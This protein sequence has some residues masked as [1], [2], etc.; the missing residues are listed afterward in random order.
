MGHRFPQGFFFRFQG[1]LFCIRQKTPPT[2]RRLR[3][4]FR[5]GTCP[6]LNPS[7]EQDGSHEP[8]CIHVLGLRAKTSA[9]GKRTFFHASCA[10]IVSAK[11]PDQQF[12]KRQLTHK[13]THENIAWRQYIFPRLPVCSVESKVSSVEC[14]V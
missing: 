7:V 6:R 9:I 14:G 13:D 5:A 1:I 12:T 10:H 3:K 2:S 4:T 8:A 11:A